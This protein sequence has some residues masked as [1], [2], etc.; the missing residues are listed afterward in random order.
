VTGGDVAEL[1]VPG[2]HHSMW[3]PEHLGELVSAVRDSI[4]VDARP[5]G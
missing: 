3:E 4:T 1:I 2:G 5:E